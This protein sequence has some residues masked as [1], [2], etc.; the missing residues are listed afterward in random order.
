MKRVIAVFATACIML[1]GIA[2]VSAEEKVFLPSDITECSIAVKTESAIKN[3]NRGAVICLGEVDMTG[4]Q[5]LYAEADI[6]LGARAEGETLAVVTDDPAKGNPIGY[7]ALTTNGEGVRFGTKLTPTEG[8]HKLYLV[9][10]YGKGNSDKN[11]MIKKFTLSDAPYENNAAS[12]KVSDDAVT[13]VYSDTWEASD[14]MGRRVADYGEVGAPK[15]EERIVGMYYWN[16]FSGITGEG[17]IASDI[18]K[19]APTAKDD[20]LHEA[21]PKKVSSF[22]WS[23]PVF[24]YYSTNDIWVLRRHAE[25]LATAGVD[26]IFFDYTND[27]NTYLPMLDKVVEA[28]RLAK[29]SGVK[30]PKISAMTDWITGDTELSYRVLSSLYF[31]A[32]YENDYSDVWFYY[33]GKPFLFGS[34]IPE[35]AIPNSKN[36]MEKY[37]TSEEIGEFFSY[38]VH[39]VKN[40][41]KYEGWYFLENFPQVLRGTTE[42]G[43]TE[44]M[45]VGV[46]INQSTVIGSKETGAFS[47]PY[48]KGRG[49]SEAFGEDYSN[50]GKHNAWFFREQSALALEAE[51]HFVAVV[52]WN[53]WKAA[54]LETYGS[55][56]NAFVDTFDDEN[57]RDFEP[58]RG[59]LKDGYYYLLTDFIRKYKGVRK[60]PFAENAKTID[61]AGGIEQWSDVG[62][63][64]YNITSRY[65]RVPL[66]DTYTYKTKQ[67]NV[68]TRAKASYD[69]DNFYFMAECDAPVIENPE[70]MHLLVNTDRNYA[71]GWEGY[72][73]SVNVTGRDE[74]ALWQNG[75]WVKAGT[76]TEGISGHAY[77]L[78][79]PRIYVSEGTPDISF[80]WTDGVGTK[81]ILD[82]Y[83]DGSVAPLGRFNYRYYEENISLTDSQRW[84]LYDV[85]LLKAGKASMVV[86]GGEQYVYE[87]DIRI[88]PVEKDG[89]LYV[90]SDTLLELLGYGRSKTEYVIE[91]N[92][93]LS[94]SFNMNYELTEME[95]YTWVYTTVGTKDARINGRST[96][97]THPLY[98]ENGIIW[99]PL[100]YLE[101]CHGKVVTALGDGSYIL[102]SDAVSESVKA[103]AIGT[104]PCL[105]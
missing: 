18:I 77:M 1:S 104:L 33:E 83:V 89:M 64:Y 63:M 2:A 87:K 46:A 88:T 36:D 78:S 31:H 76:A 71:T 90:P 81:D 21:W 9:G 68:I 74:V 28:F 94:Y 62:P 65:E 99:V 17:T 3:P 43:R 86:N 84:D 8:V 27:G 105:D 38:R 100:S 53:E 39:G 59:E 51:S 4:K 42:D 32:F 22:Y 67:Y 92:R 95:N 52:G 73:L 54:R 55:F 16:W 10:V 93:F 80:K 45:S 57:S 61:V 15:N 6:S 11:I 96:T 24:G 50:D 98:A 66:S 25:M 44:F 102:S 49:Y 60:T 85:S 72:D 34:S 29:E 37:V 70:F 97:L 103:S 23:E 48:A 47:D 19:K 35:R 58:S 79:V 7:I 41:P 13:D 101:I 56:N 30:V 26:V 40:N 12:E 69:A 91:Y 5:S 14:H 75:A 82:F 20:Y